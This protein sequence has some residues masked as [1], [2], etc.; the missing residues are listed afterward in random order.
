V[1]TSYVFV[2]SLGFVGIWWPPS[3]LQKLEWFF[4]AA[5]F[6]VALKVY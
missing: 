4:H 3:S 5:F 2:P 1:F 6:R